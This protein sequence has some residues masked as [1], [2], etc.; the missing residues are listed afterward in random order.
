MSLHEDIS[1]QVLRRIVQEWAGGSAEL[2]EVKPLHGGCI[3]TTLCLH[4]Q[5]G[6]KAVLKISPHRV[7]RAHEEEAYQLNLLR[8]IG[9]PTPEVYA[10]KLGDLEQPFSYILMEF[11]EGVDLADARKQATA[12]QFDRLQEHL[13]ELLLRMHE[14][15]AE[16]YRRV[17]APGQ[18]FQSWPGFYRDVYDPIWHE[19]EKHPQL[20]VKVRKLIGKVHE[21]LGRLIVHDDEPRLVHWDVW[22]TNILAKPDPSGRWRVTALLD[23][24]CKYAHFE[25]ELAYME[26]FHTST[27]AFLKAYQ[28]VRRLSSDYHRIRKPIYQLYPLINHLNLFG[29]EYL[30]PL[31]AAVERVGAVV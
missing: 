11:V 19:A 7:N 20:P 4:L 16:R 31:L 25:A 6:T 14:H 12:E 23:P 10:W 3:N 5:D 29:N 28:A 30:K 1:W 18:A 2:T 22:A 26:L 8:D 9:I 15:T 13:A 21:R 27:P 17:A 24:N